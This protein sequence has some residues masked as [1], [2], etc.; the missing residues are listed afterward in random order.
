MSDDQSGTDQPSTDSGTGSDAGTSS[1]AATS[2]D[3]SATNQASAGSGTGSDA[4]TPNIVFADLNL[5]SGGSVGHVVPSLAIIHSND[6]FAVQWAAKNVGS[7][8]AAAFTDLLVITSI[9][10]GCP[11][12]DDQNHPV[13]FDSSQSGNPQDYTE[14]PLAA[15]A[16]SPGLQPNVGPF[17]TGSYKLTVTLAQGVANTTDFNCIPII[18][19]E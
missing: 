5:P 8:N 18:D 14:G 3:Q 17:A 4:G 16:T 12:S 2:A 15:G 7:G 11:G 6:T 1:Q 9:P 13:V 10:E 19:P